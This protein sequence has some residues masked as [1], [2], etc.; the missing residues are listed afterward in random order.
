VTQIIYIDG[1]ISSASYVDDV[2]N[3]TT[4]STSHSLSI[5]IGAEPSAEESTRLVAVAIHMLSANGNPVPSITAATI[6]GISASWGTTASAS[7]VTGRYSVVWI[8]ALVPTGTTA[9]VAITLDYSAIVY[10]RSFRV[11]GLIS[12]TPGH[13]DEDS[14]VGNI[15]SLVGNINVVFGGVALAACSGFGAGTWTISGV[16]ED[17]SVSGPWSTDGRIV[18][19]HLDVTADETARAV[20]ITTGSFATTAISLA[21][22]AFR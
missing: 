3:G 10:F 21:V 9:T 11:V 22:L 13:N 5:D 6:G 4:N 18:G 15:T 17:Y 12:T 16:T 8:W 1:T 2:D 7:R 14:N 20:T 19:G